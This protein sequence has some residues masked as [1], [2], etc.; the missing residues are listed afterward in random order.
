MMQAAKPLIT[1]FSSKP[2]DEQMFSTSPHTGFELNFLEARL[3]HQTVALAESAKAVC[4]FVNDKIDRRVVSRLREFKRQL[5]STALRGIQQ[6]GFASRPRDGRDDCAC[7]RLFA[8]S[9]RRTCS[10][11]DAQPEPQVPQSL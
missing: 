5:V 3:T 4:V 9:G 6:R 1:F 11:V 8:S 10:R 7:A 2:Y